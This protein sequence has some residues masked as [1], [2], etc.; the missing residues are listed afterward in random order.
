MLTRSDPYGVR[1]LFM[2]VLTTVIL[3]SFAGSADWSR[4]ISDM[5]R[6]PLRAN[7]KQQLAI[8]Y[9]NYAIELS[10][11]GS[12]REA[13]AKLERALALDA[14]NAKFKRNLAMVYLNHAFELRQQRRS[15]SF[16]SYRHWDAKQL[17]GKA[18][19]YD[20]NLAAAYI[21][22]GDIEYDNQ[23]LA[24][25]KVAWNKAKSLDTSQPGI[26]QRM[27]KLNAEYSVEEQFDRTGNSFFDLRYQ[28]NINRST[29]FD[30]SKTL[31]QAR[32][33]VGRD[34]N[35]RPRHKIVVLIY[36]EEDFAQVR[37]VPDWVAG[38]YD[39]KIRVPFPINP[40]AQA[41]VKPTLY[42]EYTHALIHDMTNNRCPV[43]LNEG[44]AEYQ[45]AKL[46]PASLNGLRA[47]VRN[48][49]LVPLVNLDAGFKS[50]D[51]ETAALAYQQSYSIVYFL[52][53][54]YGFFRIRRTL[55]QLGRGENFEDAL[56]QEFRLSVAQLE[57]QWKRWLPSL[58]K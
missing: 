51:P 58:V 12:W 33:D 11:Q 14:G 18:I 2:F 28:D 49:R 7:S 5:E 15:S 36:S 34:L 52:A 3:S 47:A 25:A 54:K 4:I 29:A 56:E 17:A 6:Q 32:R 10:N 13:E 9:N 57:K 8:A 31:S 39:G 55:E 19:R 27:Q 30:L 1:L 21:L 50:P 38:I 53:K 35:Y 23:R 43:W 42:H 20:R 37:R 24:Q 48:D 44:I 22:I 41:T 40:T 26:E 16:S 45:E 46:R